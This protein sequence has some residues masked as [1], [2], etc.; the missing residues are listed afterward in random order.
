MLEHS[1][2]TLISYKWYLRYRIYN[3]SEPG[4]FG[5]LSE[6]DSLAQTTGNLIIGKIICKTASDADVTIFKNCTEY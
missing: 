6:S 1:F 2:I 3:E 4:T 5:L